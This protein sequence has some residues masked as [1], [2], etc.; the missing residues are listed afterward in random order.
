MDPIIS[1]NSRIRHPE[2]FKIGKGSILDDY[3]YISSKAI[4]GDYSHIASGC[5][6]AGGFEQTFRLG[7]FSSLSSGV[8]VWC[9]SDDFVND[10]VCSPSIN[11]IKENHIAGDV[12]MENYTA[13]GSNSVIMPGN[14]LPEGVT[15]GALSFV[16]AFYEFEAWTVYAGTPI[17]PIKARN[18]DAI[19]RQVKKVNLE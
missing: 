8:K 19:L 12:T 16:P 6:I 17:R 9:A 15:I 13:V 11:S 18:K 5:S 3:C 14:H 7:D 4:V 2:Y 1:K 10:V